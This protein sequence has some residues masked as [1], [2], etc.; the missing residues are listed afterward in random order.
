MPPIA[1]T[2]FLSVNL[3]RITAYLHTYRLWE[4]VDSEIKFCNDPVDHMTWGSRQKRRTMLN[5]QNDYFWHELSTKE[6][7][8][9]ASI[10]NDQRIGEFLRQVKFDA[11][12][13]KE[14][15]DKKLKALGLP[16]NNIS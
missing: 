6:K 15:A 8:L 9:A 3:D 1:M 2:D 4:R 13:F 12:A 5:E 7:E 11:D 14:Y 10:V 16:S